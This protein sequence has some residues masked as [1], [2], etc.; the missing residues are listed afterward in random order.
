VGDDGHDTLQSFLDLACALWDCPPPRRM[1][2]WLIYAAAELSELVS[3]LLGTPCPL[4]RDFIDIGR[5][6]YFGD[7]SRFR[8]ELVPV[9]K[10]ADIQSGI[11]EMLR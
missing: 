6:S 9:L 2:L 10:H 4:T 5:V 7:T 3:R 1:P 11:Q 8:A